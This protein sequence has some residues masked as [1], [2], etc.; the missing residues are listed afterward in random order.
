MIVQQNTG[1]SSV[2]LKKEPKY[3][4]NYGMCIE[5]AISN[6]PHGNIININVGKN[7]HIRMY[8]YTFKLIKVSIDFIF[9]KFYDEQKSL[10]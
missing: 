5:V 7:Y 4:A 8:F 3:L 9:I 1:L 10:F 6:R 2:N